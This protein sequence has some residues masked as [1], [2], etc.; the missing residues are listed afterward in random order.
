MHDDESQIKSKYSV[1][2][3][4]KDTESIH[5]TS[6]PTNDGKWVAQIC[7]KIN[8]TQQKENRKITKDKFLIEI[9]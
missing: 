7:Y 4:S 6:Q 3:V 5:K 9:E 1:W 2:F 8:N